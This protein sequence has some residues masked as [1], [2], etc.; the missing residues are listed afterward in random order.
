M[1]KTVKFGTL[2][3][4][5]NGIQTFECLSPN[6]TKEKGKITTKLCLEMIFFA[7]DSS[8]ETIKFTVYFNKNAT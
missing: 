8:S 4:H 5:N 1:Y 3:C 7:F 6:F 2:Q